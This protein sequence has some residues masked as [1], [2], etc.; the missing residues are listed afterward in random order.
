MQANE[1]L[2]LPLLK[3]YSI[4][5]HLNSD[6]HISAHTFIPNNATSFPKM[7]DYTNNP[8]STTGEVCYFQVE[9]RFGNPQTSATYNQGEGMHQITVGNSGR[10]LVNICSNRKG[11]EPCE[12]KFAQNTNWGWTQFRVTTDSI[13]VLNQGLNYT[14]ATHPIYSF[15]IK[16]SASFSDLASDATVKTGQGS[17]WLGFAFGLIALAAALT[18]VKF[19]RDRKGAENKL[20]TAILQESEFTRVQ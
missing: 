1:D 11:N 8:V 17:F 15:E 19:W 16:R 10:S 13:T 20:Q 4:D 6:E 7:A 18:A 12:F 14:D 3:K 5:L 2:L 9:E